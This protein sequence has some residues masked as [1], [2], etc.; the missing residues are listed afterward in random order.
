M[1]YVEH[2]PSEPAGGALAPRTTSSALAES[3]GVLTGGAGLYDHQAADPISTNA[4]MWAGMAV[5][6][7]TVL[8]GGWLVVRNP[9]FSSG[10]AG[11]T[12]DQLG[13][14]AQA[15][16]G[17][18]IAPGSP[19]FEGRQLIATKPCGGCHVI[20]GVPGASGA[21]GPNLAGVAGRTKIAGG[22][23]NNSGPEDLKTWILNPPGKK[24]GTLMP[25]VGLTDDE[26]TKIVEFL[27]TL[28]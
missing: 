16:A 2:S 21:V 6:L 24:P 17:P 15:A 7:V 27:E 3:P 10:R 22:A 14:P 11:G 20:P 26:A 25:N 1:W 12:P 19:A 13:Q 9:A 28:K 8:L 23:V 18:E 5:I 4:G